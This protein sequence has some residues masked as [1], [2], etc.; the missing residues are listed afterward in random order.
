M[1]IY[2]FPYKLTHLQNAASG[3]TSC[4]PP[5]PSASCFPDLPLRHGLLCFQNRVSCCFQETHLGSLMSWNLPLGPQCSST[6]P[7]LAMTGA[8]FSSGPQGS[9]QGVTRPGLVGIEGEKGTDLSSSGYLQSDHSSSLVSDH[10]AHLPEHC[11]LTLKARPEEPESKHRQV[12]VTGA[13]RGVDCSIL[14]RTFSEAPF[15]RPARPLGPSEDGPW[16]HL[17]MTSCSENKAYTYFL[18]SWSQSCGWGDFQ[19]PIQS[20]QVEYE[21][22]MLLKLRW[23][24]LLAGDGCILFSKSYLLFLITYVIEVQLTYRVVGAEWCDSG[25]HTHTHIIF[26]IFFFCRLLWGIDYSFLCCTVYLCCLL[27]IY[28]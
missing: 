8:W 5:V 15:P 6:S 22:K 16:L 3:L 17:M 24:M 18:Q 7:L 10:H 19:N 4:L 2:I 9:V 13:G 26:E 25:V 11:T 12:P 20:L 14:P 21:A 27:H 1:G 28:F 23:I